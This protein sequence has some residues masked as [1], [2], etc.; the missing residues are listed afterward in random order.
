M[1]NARRSTARGLRSSSQQQ[2]DEASTRPAPDLPKE[3]H[4]KG[5]QRGADQYR[6]VEAEGPRRH[7]DRHDQRREAEDQQDIR[8]VAAD[9]IADGDAGRAGS[10]GLQAGVA[11]SP[12]YGR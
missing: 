3:E 7:G 10:G 5:E 4:Q 6:A 8:D 2:G 12:F 11:W 9:H 1:H